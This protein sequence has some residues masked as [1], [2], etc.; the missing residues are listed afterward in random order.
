MSYLALGI[1]ISIDEAGRPETHL[2]HDHVPT[3][4]GKHGVRQ[5]P[6]QGRRHPGPI[7]RQLRTEQ[8]GSPVQHQEHSRIF[9][10][11]SSTSG[12]SRMPG[13]AWQ[14]S[15]PATCTAPAALCQSSMTPSQS[16]A[17]R[18]CTQTSKIVKQRRDAV[19]PSSR[20]SVRCAR[21]AKNGC[22]TP[23]QPCHMHGNFA[24]MHVPPKP[25]GPRPDRPRH[26]PEW[27]A[28]RCSASAASQAS[29]AHARPRHVPEAGPSRATWTGR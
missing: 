11:S 14:D 9:F 6:H 29:R 26:G 28:A 1:R 27:V 8:C 19:S 2:R 7:C 20:S 18:H 13:S 12:L 10:V 5:G 3:G 24:Y 15:Q 25:R 16:C 17:N 23:A 22:Q 21:P 4:A